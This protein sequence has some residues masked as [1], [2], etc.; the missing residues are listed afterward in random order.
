MG[1]F[2]PLWSVGTVCPLSCS[3]RWHRVC[4]IIAKQGL[5]QENAVGQQIS[6]GPSSARGMWWRR[7]QL[8]AKLS[9]RDEGTVGCWGG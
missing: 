1:W 3:R 7:Q 2:V 5:L 4:A 9:R 6:W 8:V